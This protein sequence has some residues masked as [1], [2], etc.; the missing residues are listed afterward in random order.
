METLN[1]R[2]ISVTDPIGHAVN[3]TKQILFSPFSPEKWF[4]IGFCAWLAGLG[5]HGGGGGGGGGGIHG[6][7]VPSGSP[8]CSQEVHRVGQEI[9]S[10]ISQN[11][12]WLLPVTVAIVLLIVV[13]SIVIIWLKSRGQFMFL[14]C[15]VRNRGAIAA[16]WAEY[17]KDGNSLF[18]FKLVLLLAGFALSLAAIIPI[19]FIVIM[20]VRN[21]FRVFLVGPAIAGGLLLL[22][23]MVMGVVFGVV[24]VL[25]EDFVVPIMY[26]RRTGVKAAW[27]ECLALLSA[28]PGVIILYLLF[29]F[30]I[31]LILGTLSFLCIMSACC[32]FCCVTWIFLIPFVGS[33]LITVLLLPLAVWR[34]SYSA[35]FLSQFGPEYNVFAYI[36]IPQPPV[37]YTDGILP[38]DSE[39]QP[40]TPPSDGLDI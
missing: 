11:L 2:T 5:S 8:S 23:L 35:L 25:T 13:I 15:I 39:P 21:E 18:L 7:N 16:P 14:D 33:Y 24:K 19:I 27:K 4:A 26:L 1:N 34:R 32:V 31:D 29:L 40:G 17:R 22:A 12:P 38:A 36:G 3:K 10:F 9:G 30:I 28:R 37:A 20:F 6:D